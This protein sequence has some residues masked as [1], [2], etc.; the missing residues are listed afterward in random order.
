MAVFDLRGKFDMDL[1][2]VPTLKNGLLLAYCL[3][4]CGEGSFFLNFNSYIVTN[5]P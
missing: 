1:L 3:R 2:L 4:I 5:S